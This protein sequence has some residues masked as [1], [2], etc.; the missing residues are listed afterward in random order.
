MQ[1]Y[2]DPPFKRFPGSGKP[3]HTA[4]LAHS[5]QALFDALGR[6]SDNR[7]TIASVRR[8]SRTG[9]CACKIS[10]AAGGTQPERIARSAGYLVDLTSIQGG[11]HKVK[12]IGSGQHRKIDKWRV[13]SV[14]CHNSPQVFPQ[15]NFAHNR[16]NGAI[17]IGNTFRMRTS[18]D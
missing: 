3:F 14:R 10:C 9:Q 1:F 12:S 18:R 15:D 2:R 4:P 11:K 16:Q 8:Y 7:E 6:L 17:P 5:G 13:A